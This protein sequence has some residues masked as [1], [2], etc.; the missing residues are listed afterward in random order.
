[1]Q[2][3]DWWICLKRWSWVKSDKKKCAKKKTK[4]NFIQKGVTRTKTFILHNFSLPTDDYFVWALMLKKT[5]IPFSTCTLAFL[6]CALYTNTYFFFTYCRIMPNFV[7]LE[8]NFKI[9]NCRKSVWTL[10]KDA[11]DT[12]LTTYVCEPQSRN[13]MRILG[14]SLSSSKFVPEFDN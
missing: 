4:S 12:S 1:M 5:M 13:K 7:F 9:F 3:A 2:P 11:S 6:Q 8:S 14:N 10:R